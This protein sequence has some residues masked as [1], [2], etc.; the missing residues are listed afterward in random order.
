M[1]IHPMR[2][3]VIV[4]G[5]EAYQAA[6]VARLGLIQAPVHGSEHLVAAGLLV[7]VLPQLTA[8][9][10]QVSLLYPHRRQVAPRVQAV[11][12]WI[13]ALVQPG[14]TSRS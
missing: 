2:C 11:L 5:T 6:C 10:M 1:H 14:L 9:P 3:P 13:T 4:N 7:K 12:Q 8:A